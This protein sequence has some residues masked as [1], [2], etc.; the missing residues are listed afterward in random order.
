LERETLAKEIAEEEKRVANLDAWVTQWIRAKQYRHFM[1]VL[2]AV[3]KRTTT[4]SVQI[5]KRGRGL[6]G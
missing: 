2:Q 1:E 4:T 5:Q 3:W 6:S